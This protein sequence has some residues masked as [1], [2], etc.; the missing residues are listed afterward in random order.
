[1]QSC[2]EAGVAVLALEAGKT[3][4]LDKEDLL[5]EAEGAGLTIVGVET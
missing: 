2:V 5:R 4:L 3:L 1:V